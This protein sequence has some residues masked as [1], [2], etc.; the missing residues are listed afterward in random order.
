MDQPGFES[1]YPGVV[2]MRTKPYI[3]FGKAC[4][5]GYE[6][7]KKRDFEFVLISNQDGRFG[8]DLI[9]KLIQPLV[10]DKLILL[11]SPISSRY[12]SFQIEPFYIQYYLKDCENLIADLLF[13]K[14]RKDFYETKSVTGAC[15]AIRVS[16]LFEK[17]LF[18][19]VF[20]MYYEDEDLC[21]RVI[22]SG[23]K[24]VLVPNALFFHQ[25]SNTSEGQTV[26]K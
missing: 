8:K 26:Q 15:L 5:A 4:N 11:S 2:R 3:G 18:D 6:Y 22:M 7:F 19:E 13:N 10:S 25:H 9:S 17:K 12:N 20:F 1:K 24:I 14:D 21:R 23:F 16:P